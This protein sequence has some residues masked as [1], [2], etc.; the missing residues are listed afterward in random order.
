M[1]GLILF[2]YYVHSDLSE[3]ILFARYCPVALETVQSSIQCSTSN[4]GISGNIEFAPMLQKKLD[5]AING[6]FSANQW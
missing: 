5:L 2:Y 1:I 4:G 6:E 3:I